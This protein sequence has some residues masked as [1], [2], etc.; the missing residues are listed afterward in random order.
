M[1][2][3]SLALL[4]KKSIYFVFF[5]TRYAMELHMVH[6]SQDG[7]GVNRTAVVG[8]LYKI[9]KPDA[10]LS[11][12]WRSD[13]FFQCLQDL[14]Y[15]Y[16]GFSSFAVTQRY[17]FHK[18]QRVGGTVHWNSWSQQDH[19]KGCKQEA[20]QIQ[21]LTHHPSLHWRCSLEHPPKGNPVLTEILARSNISF[22]AISTES[23]NKKLNYIQIRTVS[24][25][26]VKA[27]REAVH[28]VSTVQ[29]IL[30]IKLRWGMTTE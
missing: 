8:V 16:G 25:I 10:F 15:I 11:K 23:A 13:N 26:Q 27:L 17:H 5:V 9:G 30:L 20:L 14:K 4:F 19:Q 28:E 3:C 7:K 2:I 12:V 29:S 21:W 24:R 6:V 1:D 18:W 22:S